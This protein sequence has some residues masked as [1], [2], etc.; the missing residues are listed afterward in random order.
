VGLL[1]VAGGLA[2]GV[3]PL[4]DNSFLT[5]LATGR[6]MIDIE[7][8]PRTDPFTFTV[9]G[10]PWVV[11]SWLASMVYG[12]VEHWLE[13]PGLTVL[14]GL[15]SAA[16][17]AA[18]WALT[19][20][21]QAVIARFA[22]SALVLG[23]GVRTWDERPL[24]FG[25]F[26]LA[27]VL[28]AA[29][30]RVD[31][32][33]MVPTMWVWVNVHGSFPLGLV[34]LALLALGRRFDGERPTVELRVLAWA[35]AG[36]LLGAVNPFGLRILLF[37]FE[38]VS[39]Q[40]VLRNIV[41]WQSPD[42][43]NSSARIFLLLVVVAIAGLVRRPSWRAAVPLMAFVP[44]ALLSARNIPVASLV[45]VPGMAVGLSGLG[46][47]TGSERRPLHWVP[48]AAVGTLALVGLVTQASDAKFDLD[49][50][51]RR[52][53][54]WLKDEG[55]LPGRIVAR[56]FVG[57]FL[58]FRF[59]PQQ[60]VYID[61]RYDLFPESLVDQYLDLRQPG[62]GWEEQL[63]SIGADA[64]LWEIDDPLGQLLMASPNW[65][66]AYEDDRWFVAVPVSRGP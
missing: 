25:L 31:A 8:I 20:P 43:S 56:D 1:V 57:N 12:V 37:P 9:A 34:A 46:S 53:A 14:F 17:A 64:V 30:G 4:N 58:E 54:R 66:V 21:A 16:L 13:E 59:G 35:G 24:L 47:I 44:A 48:A 38:F 15:T 5:H 62:L 45:L 49:A 2:I 18:V 42:F 23:V 39:R 6:L 22:I 36:T 50:Y 55:L 52:A 61:D 65:R 7:G 33:W 26:L 41:E 40:D 28:L 32:R 19:R 3:Q 60:S 63:D 27:V 51:P 10:D 11:Q 29:E